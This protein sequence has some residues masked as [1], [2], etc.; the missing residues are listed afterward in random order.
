MKN[1]DMMLN[2][3][4][5]ANINYNDSSNNN[6]VIENKVETHRALKQ[7]DDKHSNQT[8]NAEYSNDLVSSLTLSTTRNDENV[9]IA[10]QQ[11][12]LENENS[13]Y[14]VD[15]GSSQTFKVNFGA[16]KT[17][18]RRSKQHKIKQINY[19]NELESNVPFA[20]T[21][22][23]N[24]ENDVEKTSDFVGLGLG[25]EVN[26]M[27][28]KFIVE[29][30]TV[31]FDNLNEKKKIVE[32]TDTNNLVA[33]EN[34]KKQES[35]IE[36]VETNASQNLINEQLKPTTTCTSQSTVQTCEQT[37]ATSATMMQNNVNTNIAKEKET[38]LLKSF[39]TNTV[40]KPRL[41][42]ASRRA[43]R[44]APTVVNN[45]VNNNTFVNNSNNNNKNNGVNISIMF[46][47]SNHFV[48]ANNNNANNNFPTKPMVANNKFFENDFEI[49]QS[50]KSHNKEN[51][52]NGSNTFKTNNNPQFSNLLQTST[53]LSNTQSSF[54]KNNNNNFNNNINNNNKQRIRDHHT[55]MNFT[56]TTTTTGVNS[57]TNTY[58]PTSLMLAQ[59]Q[60]QQQQPTTYLSKRSRTDNNNNSNNN[61]NYF[62][63]NNATM[64]NLNSNNRN[65]NTINNI[66][67]MNSNSSKS[68]W[69]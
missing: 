31:R 44:S 59:Q 35:K 8:L 4:C 11:A 56:T 43:I 32:I 61:T 22:D 19:N 41:L 5:N 18:K 63:S 16:V 69:R 50:F 57:F 64:N 14:V 46:D 58:H 9:N 17:T 51:I 60:Q 65:L 7:V 10:N 42:G 66:V 68:T 2:S 25:V 34:C 67:S 1:D 49:M 20:Q 48:S 24:T 13:E 55:L 54:N 36:D 6:G 3:N 38:N 23:V 27:Q 15:N 37:A 62:N 26:S 40:N 12:V 53:L 52:L 30:K 45:N 39:V 29:E 21:T 33:P 47:E 28:K